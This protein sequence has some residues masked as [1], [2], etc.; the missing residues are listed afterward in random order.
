[1]LNKPL[2]NGFVLILALTGCQSI[3]GGA[4]PESSKVQD[5][6]P[7]TKLVGSKDAQVVRS[8]T[9]SDAERPTS[10][11]AELVQSGDRYHVILSSDFSTSKGPDLQVVLHRSKDLISQLEPPTFPLEASEY[12]VLGNLKSLAG[13]QTYAVPET[14]NLEEYGSVAVWC[15][16]FNATFGSANL[17]AK[18][19]L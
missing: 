7:V 12:L 10:G 1:M 16:K 8:G 9:F 15:E 5:N 14:V 13:Q 18:G 19:A 3:D 17:S 2:L 6:Q 11:S 4:P